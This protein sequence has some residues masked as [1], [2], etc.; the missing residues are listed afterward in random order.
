[1]SHPDPTL[2]DVLALLEGYW[3]LETAARPIRFG[4]KDT[5][6]NLLDPAGR[7]LELLYRN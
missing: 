5:K 6:E 2:A 3:Q 1:M 4:E 7:M